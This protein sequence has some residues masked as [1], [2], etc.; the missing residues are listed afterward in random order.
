MGDW[1]WNLELMW[2][3][4]RRL[5]LQEHKSVGVSLLPPTSPIDSGYVSKKHTEKLTSA[6][7]YSLIS[8]TPVGT[9][10]GGLTHIY[11]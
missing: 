7:A 3:L 8:F 4:G 6:A 1:K 11:I 9:Q 2:K 10:Q 5:N